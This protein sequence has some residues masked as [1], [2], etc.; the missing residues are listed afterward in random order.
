M[1]FKG[2][3]KNGSVNMNNEIKDTSKDILK[4]YLWVIIFAIAFAYVESAVVIYLRKIYFDGSFY[5][6]I[7]SLWENGKRVV[8]HFVLIEFGREIST[9]IMLIAI[10][11]AAGRNEV[12]KFSFFI[13]AF[14]IWDIFYYIWLWILSGWPESFMTWDLLFFIPLP[15]V[16]P[17]ITPVL[18]ALAM[19]AAGSMMIYC[20]LK[21]CKIKWQMKDWIIEF[22]CGFLMIV[23]FCWDWKNIIRLPDGISRDGIPTEFAWWL[24]L[25]PYIFSIVYFAIRLRHIVNDGKP[26]P[27]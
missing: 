2:T 9:I 11:W 6:P 25:P 5:F 14:G 17:V 3:G 21:I 27:E 23:A 18:I 10:G 4:S 15:W 1:I 26:F 20:D 8:D 22:G 12:Q 13:I 19:V 7:N 16:G 24:F